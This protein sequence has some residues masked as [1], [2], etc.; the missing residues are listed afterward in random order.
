MTDGRTVQRELELGHVPPEAALAA[1]TTAAQDAATSA[2]RLDAC[3]ALGSLS[4][5]AH[6]A[7]WDVAERAAFVLLGIARDTD[8]PA[9][10][11]ALLGAIG[12]GFRNVWLLPYV[13]ARLGDDDENVVA[14]AIAAAGGLAFPALE[15]AIANGFLRS[16]TP[17]ALRL[18]AI[19]AL[20]RMGASSADAQLAG[21]IASSDAEAAASLEALTEIRSR[22]GEDAALAMLA[23]EPTREV[24]VA[25]VR[26]LAEVG[27]EDV[28]RF[29]PRLAR[30]ERA[31]LR[32]AASRA[33]R[34][35]QAERSRDAGERILT[36]LTEQ[37]RA[38]RSALAR[39]L[40]TL[41]VADVLAQA[42]L[43]LADDPDGV[44][45]IVAE[46]RA[47]EVTRMLLAI[48]VDARFAVAVRARA[49][50]AV[51]AN[52]AWEQEALLA[53][54]GTSKDVPVR[55]AA[56]QTIGAFAS[57]SFVLE[58]LGALASDAAPTVRGA[59]L[60]A[61]QLSA[62]P[63]EL[64]GPERARAEA[65][66][67][68][69]L[70]DEEPSV[71]RRAA[72]VAGNLD[73]SSL[74]PELIALAR[75]E[76]ER[77]DLRVAAFVGLAEIG[78][79][80]RVA[81]VVHLFNR[82]DD[83]QALGAASQA[84]ERAVVR[85]PGAERAAIARVKDRL[86]KL[87]ASSDARVRAAAARMA[88]LSAG[89]VPV[90]S[91]I[92]LADD[93]APRVREQAVSA[94]GRLRG[95]AGEAALVSALE[96]GDLAIQERAADALL[97]RGT[98]AAIEKVIDFV[99]RT[100]EPSAAL[101]I[102]SKITLPVE[103]RGAFLET[104]DAAL[105]RVPDDHAAYEPLLEL[106]LDALSAARPAAPRGVSVD[107]AIASLFPMWTRLSEVRGFAPLAKSLRTAEMLYGASASADA[108]QSAAIV[109]WSKSLE[110][111]LHAWLA[112][113]LSVLQQQPGVLWQLVDGMTGS[114][115]PGYQRWLGPRWHDPVSVGGLSVDV[116]LR[117][118][119]NALREYSERRL[120]SLDSPMSITEWSRVMLFLAIDHPTG[121]RNVLEVGCKDPDRAAKLAHQLQVLA[122]VRN[123]VT[124]RQVATSAT[125][126]EFR[127][128]YYA[129]FE[130]LTGMA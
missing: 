11:A 63:R 46:V 2:L 22:A 4:G 110:G 49:A 70:A 12:R 119:V 21:L 105:A 92:A 17:R 72:Y 83:P 55:V 6:G 53:L 84:I 108:D 121:A 64:A 65:I 75:N 37:D 103:D 25:A 111:Y 3:R 127:T 86:P 48:A 32:I 47:P 20:G 31:D 129:A 52:E 115:W 51:E 40:R 44:V 7:S 10:R 30:D 24:L 90:E 107:A 26:Y 42:E 91:V 68:G 59:L 122:Q 71:R 27:R 130:E 54:L 100:T 118:V 78:S 80:E 106:K 57:T 34:A 28:L 96:D 101:R 8:S 18:A 124:H 117:S 33:S 94:L 104:L 58:H 13:H 76:T 109:L 66:V 120:K 97:T 41:P 15:S 128:R 99:S 116:P 35:F 5:R 95:G 23:R 88:G 77:A 113:R 114:A 62:R 16:D 67:R 102:A 74:V 112:P 60:W 50:T 126:G 39:R 73:A 85:A 125:L 14:A 9:E 89:I 56:A 98:R 123:A 19:T 45:Q 69:A 87:V 43:L 38:M 1:L 82:E 29:L 81:D 79:P 61:L 36:A 93:D